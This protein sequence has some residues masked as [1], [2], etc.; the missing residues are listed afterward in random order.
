MLFFFCFERNRVGFLIFHARI[1]RHTRNSLFSLRREINM[2]LD[3][4]DRL[5][6][7][8]FRSGNVIV[9]RSLASF[10]LARGDESLGLFQNE[11]TRSSLFSL[12]SSKSPSKEN[13]IFTV[14]RV[15]ANFC[16]V[17]QSDEGIQSQFSYT[18][19]LECS[20]AVYVF[21]FRRHHAEAF[22]LKPPL[23]LATA[24]L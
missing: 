14:S 21:G 9:T 22:F 18:A 4:R 11:N 8:D 3:A 2:C 16:I 5:L 10:F 20:V 15:R 12:I 1:A 13:T 19:L 7:G 24:H 17:R 23:S 6:Q